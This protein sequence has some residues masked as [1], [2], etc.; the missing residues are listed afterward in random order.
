[1]RGPSACIFFWVLYIISRGMPL[2]D[3]VKGEGQIQIDPNSYFLDWVLKNAN[4]GEEDIFSPHDVI[5]GKFQI[6]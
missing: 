3:R 2:Q 1:M 4:I 6:L 5:W